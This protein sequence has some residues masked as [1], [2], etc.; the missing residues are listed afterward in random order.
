MVGLRSI[1][2]MLGLL[3]IPTSIWVYF[4]A[5]KIGVK[6]HAEEMTIFNTGPVGW[7]FWC[8]GFWIFAFPTYLFKREGFKKRCGVKLVQSE[9]HPSENVITAKQ[10]SDI[11]FHCPHCQQS[12]TVDKSAASMTLA[13][14]TCG[15]EITVPQPP[16]IQ[17]STRP[18]M[19]PP[20]IQDL[21]QQLR[22]LAKLK[23][24]GI[25][26]QEDFDKKKKSL[27]GV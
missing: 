23:D 18:T 2:N 22:G 13:C 12:L 6:K 7:M 19:P 15:Q 4:D 16:Q 17:F 10:M 5:K 3:V 21:D 27:L 25:I 24:E 20:N 14:P 9:Y 26:S 11:N 1:F 8:L